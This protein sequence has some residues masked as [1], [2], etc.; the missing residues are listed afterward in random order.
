MGLICSKSGMEKVKEPFSI[1]IRDAYLC[2]YRTIHASSGIKGSL[3][4]FMGLHQ[5]PDMEQV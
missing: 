4:D 2:R 5:G 1:L 3:V